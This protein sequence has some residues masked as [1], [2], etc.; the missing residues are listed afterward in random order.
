[1]ATKPILPDIGNDPVTGANITKEPLN[2]AL[3]LLNDFADSIQSEKTAADADLQSQINSHLNSTTA[4][5]D[6]SINNTSAVSGTK[7]SD[8][9]NTT[10]S[11]MDSH[12]NGLAEFHGSDDIINES[13]VVGGS[14]SEAMETVQQQV[15]ALVVS[16]TDNITIGV[17]SLTAGGSANVYTG[18]FSGLTYFGGLK[19]SATFNTPNTG[20]STININTLGAKSIKCV[21]PTGDK[22]DLKGGELYGKVLLEYDGTDFVVVEKNFLNG[23]TPST[24][25]TVTQAITSLPSSVIK[26]RADW[27]VDGNTLYNAIVNGDFANGTTGWGAVYSTNSVSNKILSNTGNGTNSAPIL[28]RTTLTPVVVG[29]N[30]FYKIRLR[31]TN[32]NCT[33]IILFLDGSVSGSDKPVAT[34]SSPVQNNWYDLYIINTPPN[35]ATGNLR[36]VARHY[37]ADAATANGK[38]M[39]VDGNIGVFAIPLTGTPYESYTAD[40]MN[41][42]VTMYFEGLKGVENPRVKSV[43]KNLFDGYKE[44]GNINSSNGLPIVQ[45]DRKRTGFIKVK[46]GVNYKTNISMNVNFYNLNYS[47]INQ[48]VGSNQFSPSVDGY[49]RFSGVAS[50][51]D[52]FNQLELGTVATAYVPYTE[53]ETYLPV[54]LNRLPSTVDSVDDD[55]VNVKRIGAGDDGDGYVLQAADVNQLVTTPTN[56]DYVRVT[57]ASL[58]GIYAQSGGASPSPAKIIIP[59]FTPNPNSSLVDNAQYVWT[60]VDTF[61]IDNANILLIVPKGTYANLAAAQAAL[62]G[63]KIMYQLATPTTTQLPISNIIVEPSGTVYIDNMYSDVD[64]YT[65]NITVSGKTFNSIEKVLKIDKNTGFETDITSTCTLTGGKDGFTSTALVSGDLVWFALE[66]TGTMIPS[67]TYSYAMDIKAATEG[68]TTAVQQIDKELASLQDFIYNNTPQVTVTTGFLANW[69]GTIKY[70]KNR[71]SMVTV[72]IDLLRSADILATAETLYT[73]PEGYRPTDTI[74]ATVN[75]LSSTD[76]SIADSF[77]NISINSSG[78][79]IILPVTSTTLTDARSI[80]LMFNYYIA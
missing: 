24:P 12:V 37:Y 30:Y 51:M 4:H 7:V 20:A 75:L 41:A 22:S 58:I 34:V 43:G 35:D 25:A 28:D 74:N 48:V 77:A 65:T 69:S 63:T 13:S 36:I 27:K 71:E 59:N 14:L 26:S 21:L 53:T 19:I 42:L 5:N 39:E 16:G 73:L 79:I 18:T 6:S 33:Q 15:N 9:L 45:A 66:A 76:V 32:A 67:F 44:D 57:R 70:R 17:Y 1:M 52:S 40:Q 80:M 50:T 10:K 55:G 61:A 68:N 23:G 49:V 8:A 31:V 46:G 60:Y 38:V 72:Y 47:F 62:A 56:F 64:F 78:Q 3:D 54:T 29:S 11:R 2:E